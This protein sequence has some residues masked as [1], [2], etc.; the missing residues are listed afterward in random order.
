MSVHSSGKKGSGLVK[1]VPVYQ[2]PMGSNPMSGDITPGR[3]GKLMA[4]VPSFQADSGKSLIG[5]VKVGGR[6]RKSSSRSMKDVQRVQQKA[7]L[8]NQGYGI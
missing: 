7:G 3:K 8:T 1:R 4:T 2:A 5:A 6:T